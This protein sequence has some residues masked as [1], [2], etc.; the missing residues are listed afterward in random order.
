MVIDKINEANKPVKYNKPLLKIKS[1]RSVAKDLYPKTSNF[2]MKIIAARG[3]GKTIFLI[4][5]LHSIINRGIL[6]HE[7]IYIFWPKFNEQD[8]WRSSAFIARNF[9]YLNEDYAKGK[10][11]TIAIRYKRK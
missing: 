1:C 10:L 5:F 9:E 4:A 2:I 8:Q 6:N 3:M 11:F 7:D